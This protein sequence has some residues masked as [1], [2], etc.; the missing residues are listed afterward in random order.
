[1]IMP[2]VQGPRMSNVQRNSSQLEMANNTRREYVRGREYVRRVKITA[3]R[4]RITTERQRKRDD[5]RPGPNRPPEPSGPPGR[6]GVEPTQNAQTQLNHA[7][8]GDGQ[9]EFKV[10]FRAMNLARPTQSNYATRSSCTR[11]MVAYQCGVCQV[12]FKYKANLKAHRDSQH[13]QS[14]I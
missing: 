6:G 14:T 4:R 7:G 12:A 3:Q 11:Y 13:N 5:Q 2:F 10:K 8:N 1:M 9:D